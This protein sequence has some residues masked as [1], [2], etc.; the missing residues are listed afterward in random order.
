MSH[1]LSSVSFCARGMATGVLK[2]EAEAAADADCLMFC[3]N[4]LVV[5]LLTSGW[6]L[7]SALCCYCHWD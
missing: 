7:I 6:L 1:R 5:S 3:A 4:L 2:A